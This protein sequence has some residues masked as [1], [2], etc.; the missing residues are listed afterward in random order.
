VLQ[1]GVQAIITSMI[2]TKFQR[3]HPHEV[4]E[5]DARDQFELC[6]SLL[7]Y[8]KAEILRYNLA[9]YSQQN[10]GCGSWN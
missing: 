10:Y 5:H 7:S 2:A 4:E 1:A 9:Q 3:L 8:I 6:E